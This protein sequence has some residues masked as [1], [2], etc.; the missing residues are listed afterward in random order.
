MRSAW[1][2]SSLLVIALLACATGTGLDETSSSETSPSDLSDTPLPGAGGGASDGGKN[3][4]GSKG[5]GAAS[6]GSSGG[7]SGSTSS[8]SGGSST[9]SGGTSTSS[10][11][12][13]C[14]PPVPGGVC[15]TLPQCG[16]AAGLKC[17]VNGGGGLT[18]CIP[19]GAI[20]EYKQCFSQNDCQKG[21]TCL[22]GACKPFCDTASDCPGAGRTCGPVYY[23]GGTVPGFRICT[24]AC[25]LTNAAAKC[26]PGLTC[27]A[28]TFTSADCV[29]PAGTGTGPG[30]C[31]SGALC[32]PG[33]V[34]QNGPTG[35]LDCM[36]WCKIGGSDCAAGQTCAALAAGMVTVAG[37][38]YGVCN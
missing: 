21:L 34:C 27:Y 15:D 31:A 32:A 33:Y 13:G 30:G 3:V 35:G 25:D 16:C 7:S 28:T 24:S 9:S 20:A 22:D 5:D 6:S 8:S 4:I 1:M 14:T 10:G 29:G 36:K 11:G 12:S 19:A 17:D 26:G 23:G 37:V 38:D 18:E 2:A